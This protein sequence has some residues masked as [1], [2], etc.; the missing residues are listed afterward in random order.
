MG[1]HEIALEMIRRTLGN[2]S[3]DPA[4]AQNLIDRLRATEAEWEADGASGA[5]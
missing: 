2:Y 1:E 5:G 3:V 4:T